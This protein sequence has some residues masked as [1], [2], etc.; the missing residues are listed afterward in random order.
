MTQRGGQMPQ[1][2]EKLGLAGP[3]PSALG[4]MWTA[5]ANVENVAILWPVGMAAVSHISMNQT[6]H[7]PSLPP[8]QD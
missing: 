6:K 7:T 4:R 8:K 2:G 1:R 5:I 3:Q